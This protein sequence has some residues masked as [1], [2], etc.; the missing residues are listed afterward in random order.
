[1]TLIHTYGLE[2]EKLLHHI[3]EYLSGDDRFVAAWLTGS[4]SRGDTDD[5]SDIDLTI[6]VAQASSAVLCAR[7]KMKAPCATEQRLEL[8]SQ[9]GEVGFAY[10]NHNN[11]PPGGTATNVLYLPH[12]L[13]VDWVLVPEEAAQRPIKSK[14]VF[15]RHEIPLVPEA[16]VADQA[17]RAEEAAEMVAFFWLM[18][19]VICKYIVRNDSVFVNF[20]LEQLSILVLGIERRIV[21]EPDTYHRGSLT[22]LS[23]TGE[24]QLAVLR[25]LCTK[26]ESLSDIVVS[27]G[28]AVY[29]VSQAG[30][31]QWL[32]MAEEAVASQQN[33][34]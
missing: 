11:A 19:T 3:T 15:Q 34:G 26:V 32:I 8:F 31:A 22:K 25:S 23:S 20:W 2:R 24:K 29:P 5:I 10:E 14:I 33:A 6:V 1:M 9:F 21:G 7:P 27:M 16:K 4:L 18:V 13:R 12:G 28:G 17:K 30:I